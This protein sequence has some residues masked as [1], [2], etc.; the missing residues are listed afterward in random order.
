MSIELK[1]INMVFYEALKVK[2][3]VRDYCQILLLILGEFVLINK[4]LFPLKLS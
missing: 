1:G 4:L 2:Y 3:F